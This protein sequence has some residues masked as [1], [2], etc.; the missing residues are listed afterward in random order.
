MR[1]LDVELKSLSGIVS[2]GLVAVALTGCM[3]WTKTHSPTGSM[4]RTL[5]GAPDNAF[6][7]P[8]PDAPQPYREALDLVLSG[9]WQEAA[10]K[11]RAF[12]QSEP[13]SNW[14]LAAQFH[15]GWCL[16]QLSQD[17]EANDV[18]SA[19]VLRGTRTPR[20]KAM[21]SIRLAVLAEKRG[22]IVEAAARLADARRLEGDL[23]EEVRELELPALIGSSRS[24]AGDFAKAD[25]EFSRSDRYLVKMRARG[26]TSEME[27][28]TVGRVLYQMGSGVGEPSI[29]KDFESAVVRFERVQFYLLSAIEIGAEPWASRAMLELQATM[30]HAEL[31]TGLATLSVNEQPSTGYNIDEGSVEDLSRRQLQSWERA[32]LLIGAL[33]RLRSLFIERELQEQGELSQMAR[34]AAMVDSLDERLQA[35]LMLDRP[36]VQMQ[37]PES[38]KRQADRSRSWRTVNPS[39]IFELEKK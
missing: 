38:L 37:T 21:A 23:P 6:L 35:R 24:R 8:I 20:L 15:L 13:N 2:V 9:D 34:L 11:L 31:A 27:E 10:N 30:V 39:P 17:S 22:D 12:L 16:E 18:F 1:M 29:W 4:I 26:Q 14:N 19:V 32:A 3:S 28:Q 5:F 7:R 36:I 33:K 25:I